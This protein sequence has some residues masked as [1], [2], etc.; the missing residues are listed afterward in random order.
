M[1]T[2]ELRRHIGGEGSRPGKETPAADCHQLLAGIQTPAIARPTSESRKP[3]SFV[4]GGQA[5]AAR[6]GPQQLKP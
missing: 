4:I 6:T 1:S 5:A 3:V 2:E